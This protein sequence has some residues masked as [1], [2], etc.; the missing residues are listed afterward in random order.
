MLNII[1][2]KPCEIFA[3]L[4]RIFNKNLNQQLIQWYIQ[5]IQFWHILAEW[6]I[7]GKT[8][9]ICQDLNQSSLLLI[10]RGTRVYC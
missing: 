8:R 10:S 6:S 9:L 7:L 5:Q 4:F 1:L 2:P 3:N